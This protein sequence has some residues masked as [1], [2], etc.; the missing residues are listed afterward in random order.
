MHLTTRGRSAGAR[1]TINSAC[2]GILVN[3]K[4][5]QRHNFPTYPLN[6]PIR[7]RNIND[8]I[9]QGGL[10]QRGLDANLTIMDQRGRTHTE[11]VQMFITNLGKDDMLLGTDWLKY[12]DPSI[13]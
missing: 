5:V 6:C 11:H 2:E 10:I 3:K 7:V 12:H 4:W 13:R 9:D 1:A 8:T